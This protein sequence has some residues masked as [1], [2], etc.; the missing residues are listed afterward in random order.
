MS[1][2]TQVN[3]SAPAKVN[4]GLEIVSRRPD[5][6][7]ELRSVLAMIAITDTLS[8]KV[9][10]DASAAGIDGI[11]G[12]TPADNL[13]MKAIAAFNQR[14]ETR[15][16][17][18]A[19]VMKA[20]P[21]PAGLGGAS[22]NAAASLVAMNHLHGNP[23]SGEVL[24]D[25]AA[26]L[27]SDVPFF[28]GSPAALA[29]GTGAVLSP[30]PS[31]TGYLLIVVPQIDLI[32][33]TAKLYGMIEPVDYSTGSHVEYIAKCLASRQVIPHQDLVNAFERPLVKLM[34]YVRKITRVMKEAGCEHVALSGSGPA[35]YALF[36]EESEAQSAKQRLQPLLGSH[37]YVIVTRFRSSPLTVN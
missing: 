18:H 4:L 2:P 35:H 20:I 21:S 23:L 14:A 33:K 34:P 3:I 37:D 24:H 17:I 10:T 13:I 26:T 31:P 25:L 8:L 11:P 27:G 29:S 15:T 32:S 12:V 36:D 5:G 1:N 19:R 6:Y 28:L 16:L 7:H 30:L 9:V 22:S